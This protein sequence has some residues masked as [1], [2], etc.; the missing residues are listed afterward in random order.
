MYP[1][2]P[3]SGTGWTIGLAQYGTY[4][5]MLLRPMDFAS[6]G[7]VGTFFKGTGFS[8]LHLVIPLLDPV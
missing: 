3:L 7:A 2:L 5:L 1:V 8:Q 4:V 6:W